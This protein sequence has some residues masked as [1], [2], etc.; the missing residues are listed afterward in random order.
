MDFSYRA[1]QIKRFMVRLA[2][3][4]FTK[5][6]FAGIF[7]IDNLLQRSKASAPRAEQR[8]RHSSLYGR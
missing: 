4:S 7:E 5:I 6:Y 2:I 8:N 3:A 1:A